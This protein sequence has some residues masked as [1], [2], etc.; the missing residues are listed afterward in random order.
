MSENYNRLF[1]RE[2]EKIKGR[3]TLL[4]HVCC[5]PCSVY[6][7]VLL[8]KY[9][10]I[11]IY[12]E[13]PNIYSYDE[14]AKRLGELERY[15]DHLNTDMKLVIP[16]YDDDYQEGL[17]KY[18]PMK[19]GGKRCVYC[20]GKRM[21]RSYDYAAKNGFDYFTTVMSISNHKNADY[22]NRLGKMIAKGKTKY[23]F[24]DFKKDRG[25]DINN[26][27]NRELDLYHQ[28]YCGCIYTYKVSQSKKKT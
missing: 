24:A 10:K 26:K 22:I 3:P 15:L 2:L 25:I 11:V 19:E 17:K 6:P 12:Y 20:Y 5:A 13:N 4:L 7:L 27:M 9:F 23:L 16:P 1:K 21:K 8:N 28:D 14:Y 18:G